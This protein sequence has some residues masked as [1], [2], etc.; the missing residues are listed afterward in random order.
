MTEY[1]FSR[2]DRT[3]EEEIAGIQELLKIVDVHAR[4]GK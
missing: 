4:Q 2:K 3:R 1:S